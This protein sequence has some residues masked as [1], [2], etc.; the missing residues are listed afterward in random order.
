MIDFKAPEKALKSTK[1]DRRNGHSFTAV[2]CMRDIGQIMA[3]IVPSVFGEFK[4]EVFD[5][6]SVA[7]FQTKFS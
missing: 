4:F 6:D 1:N 5:P 7:F 2:Y 3:E